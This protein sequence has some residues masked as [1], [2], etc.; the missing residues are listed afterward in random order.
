MDTI[1]RK[2]I[3][4]KKGK[5]KNVVFAMR[6]LRIYSPNNF[7]RYHT[8]VLAIVMLYITSLV[9]TDFVTGSLH[10]FTTFLQFP[11]PPPHFLT[12]IFTKPGNDHI[13]SKSPMCEASVKIWKK[14]R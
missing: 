7:S 2:E 5:E 10:L 13:Y 14:E 12:G 6:T 8:A 11:L 3:F 1:K 9:L 4:K